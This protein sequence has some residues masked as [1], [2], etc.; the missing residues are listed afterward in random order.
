MKRTQYTACNNSVYAF[1]RLQIGFFL[2]SLTSSTVS[3]HF[4]T[5]LSTIFFLHLQ[6]SCSKYSAT[7][8]DLPH[9]HSQLLGFQINPLSHTP[10][11]INSLHSHLHLSSFQCCL[12]LQPLA[13]SLHLH[14]HI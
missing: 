9:S 14:L 10:L 4:S 11:S 2:A 13:S 8:Y 7:S 6:F 3:L 1:F 5:N 12:F